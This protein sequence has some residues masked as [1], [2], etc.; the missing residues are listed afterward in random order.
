[1]ENPPKGDRGKAVILGS[2]YRGKGERVFPGSLL[3]QQLS[4]QSYC[5]TP[6]LCVVG[7]RGGGGAGRVTGSHYLWWG[8]Q[9]FGNL[10]VKIWPNTQMKTEKGTSISGDPLDLVSGH[11]AGRRVGV[12]KLSITCF[13]I[14][15]G[16]GLRFGNC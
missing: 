13:R 8:K 9:L 7:G 10:F 3:V 12:L 14:F 11:G 4:P 2:S 5:A 16:I 15:G 1:M 6:I